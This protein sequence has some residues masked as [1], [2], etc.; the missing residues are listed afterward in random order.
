MIR[1]ALVFLLL[2]VGLATWGLREVISLWEA[3]LNIASSGTKF[4]VNAGDSLRSVARRLSNNGVLAHPELLILYGRA[5]GLDQQIKQGEYLLPEYSTAQSLL[6]LLQSG[7]VVAYSVTFP[8]GITLAR[9]LEILAAEPA[10]ARELSGASDPRLLELVAPFKHT[11]GWFLPESYHFTQGATDLSILRRAHTA[12]RETLEREW[13]QR[14]ENLPYENS[15]EALIMASI[16][17]RETGLP[18]ERAQISGVFF[19]RLGKDM[20]LQTDP[21]VIYGLGAEF[22]GNL[23]RSHLNDEANVYNTYRHFGLPP[24]PIALPG[25]AAIHAAMHPEP[26]NSLYFVA[27]GDGGHVFSASLGAHQKAVRAYQLQR[28]K[29]YRSSPSGN[30]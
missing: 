30:N 7:Q 2:L 23:R 20:R 5:T 19:R 21:T 1:R 27:K 6:L 12:M 10:L 15:Y 25:H 3:P 11:E 28:R 18:Q 22:D 14:A 24:S 16:I 26:G 17:E 29:D 4:T 8:E 13:A 9:A